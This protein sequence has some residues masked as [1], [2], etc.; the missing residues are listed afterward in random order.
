MQCIFMFSK[1]SW[2]GPSDEVWYEN[3]CLRVN[4]L[5]KMMT[6][7]ILAAQLSKIY[8]NHCVRATA[9]NLW[10]DTALSNRPIMTI[11][12]HRNEQSL[13]R[14]N[15]RPSSKQ[16]EKCSDEISKALIWPRENNQTLKQPLQNATEHVHQI[17][18]QT[19]HSNTS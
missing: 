1:R 3:R 16:L 18:R 11:S 7:L 15:P 12:G 6:D 13:K 2:L 19:T 4:K 10:C 17:Y 8:T 14:Y 5:G 9:I